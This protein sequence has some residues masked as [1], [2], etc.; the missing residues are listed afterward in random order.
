MSTVFVVA[1]VLF[2]CALISAFGFILTIFINSLS[3]LEKAVARM[4]AAT[5]VVAVDLAV[6]QT[7]V[8]GVATNL[9][10]AQV[11]VDAV[12]SELVESQ[13]RADGVIEGSPGAA[14]DAGAQSGK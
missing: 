10:T 3:R 2:L 12:A 6:A 4:E 11:V 7:A 8:D 13:K 5:A 14:A 9:A 1:V